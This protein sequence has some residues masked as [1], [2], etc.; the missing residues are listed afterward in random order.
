MTEATG[1]PSIL[2]VCVQNGG[3]FQMAVGLMRKIAGD[4]V[5]VYSAGTK[6]GPEVSKL[7]AESLDRLVVSRCAM[8]PKSRTSTTSSMRTSRLGR[9]CGLRRWPR[10]KPAGQRVGTVGE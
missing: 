8:F 6:P 5:E 7:S 10:R 3:K 9:C 4:S 2:F 1:K